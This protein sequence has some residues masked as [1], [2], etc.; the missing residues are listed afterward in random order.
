L[1]SG[2]KNPEHFHEGLRKITET[3]PA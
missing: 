2:R 1:R 3:W